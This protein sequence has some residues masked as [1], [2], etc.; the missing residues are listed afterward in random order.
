MTWTHIGALAGGEVEHKWEKGN[1]GNLVLAIDPELV[2][3]LGAFTQKVEAL[4]ARVQGAKP[5]PPEAGE[6]NIALPG[7]R[8]EAKATATLASG[9]IR[10]ER[11]LYEGL[12]QEYRSTGGGSREI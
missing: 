7:E 12:M 11:N 10:L 4:L 1:W 2:G 8:S 3:P 5:L 6:G 9:R